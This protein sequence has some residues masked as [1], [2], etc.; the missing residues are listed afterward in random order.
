MS[1]KTL[2]LIVLFSL[3]FSLLFFKISHRQSNLNVDADQS[4]KNLPTQSVKPLISVYTRSDSKNVFLVLV[5]DNHE[6]VVDQIA[7]TNSNSNTNFSN[8]K[9]SDDNNYLFYQ[10]GSIDKNKTTPQVIKYNLNTN[11]VE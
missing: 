1:K 3:F 4:S 11:Q 9:F 6:S 7:K 2:T 8:I 10:K 5:K